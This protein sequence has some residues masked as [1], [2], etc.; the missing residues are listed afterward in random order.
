[1]HIGIEYIGPKRSAGRKTTA[2]P[3]GGLA[4][5]EFEEEVTFSAP[6]F[7]AA[8]DAKYVAAL[9]AQ[10]HYQIAS[11]TE[12]K[13]YNKHV[14]VKAQAF[15]AP[16]PE[17]PP[18]SAPEPEVVV[19]VPRPSE[20]V[21]ASERAQAELYNQAAVGVPGVPPVST[22]TDPNRGEGPIK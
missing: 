10:P 9:I 12:Q 11:D 19:T 21:L 7:I 13:K 5:W 20:D 8:V 16:A 17:A 18:P 1:M 3:V 15:I 4:H 14:G 2:L 22:I 6:K